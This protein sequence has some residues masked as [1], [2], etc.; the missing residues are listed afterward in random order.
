MLCKLCFKLVDPDLQGR[1]DMI[2]VGLCVALDD[3]LRDSI[4]ESELALD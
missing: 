1:G 3:Q 4:G 2:D